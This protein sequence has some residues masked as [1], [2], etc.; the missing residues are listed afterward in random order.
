[1]PQSGMENQL[2]HGLVSNLEGDL[3]INYGQDELRV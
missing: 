3:V 2:M 1:M